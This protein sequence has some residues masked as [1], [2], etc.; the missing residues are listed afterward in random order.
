M[1]TK[2]T[3]NT[4]K[5]IALRKI[6]ANKVSKNFSLCSASLLSKKKSSLK[7]RHSRTRARKEKNAK[8]TFYRIWLNFWTQ[9]GK[10]GK[11]KSTL[12][13]LT[14]NFPLH[15]NIVDI[16]ICS[17]CQ[18]ISCNRHLAV[19]QPQRSLLFLFQFRCQKILNVTQCKLGK[20]VAVTTVSVNSFFLLQSNFCFELF[21]SLV[22]VFDDLLQVTY[23]S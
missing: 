15:K 4:F 18:Y 23:Q 17:H 22:A 5:K 21:Q 19:I 1:K 3:K 16:R 14:K 12:N 20:K 8:K 13:S 10:N 2:D 6:C 7:S 9:K 11:E